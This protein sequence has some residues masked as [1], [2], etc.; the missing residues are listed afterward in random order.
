M[1]ITPRVATKAGTLNWAISTPLTRPMA[2][3]SAQASTATTQTGG[4]SATPRAFSVTPCIRK[5]A[6]TPDRP[7]V[8]PT[9]RSMP[10]LRM[11]SSIPM[12]RI[13]NRATCDAMV[14]KLP[15]DR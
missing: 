4:Y 1:Y 12:A 9:D 11:T 6:T 8:D 5:P 15:S 2:A 3:P 10:P 13:P 14:R 7:S